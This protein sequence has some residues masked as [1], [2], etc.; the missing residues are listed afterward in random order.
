LR[1]SAVDYQTK[2]DPMSKQKKSSAPTDGGPFKKKWNHHKKLNG[3]KSPIV[4]PAKFQ[5]GKEELGGDYFDCTGYGQS[6]RFMKTVQKVAN[7]IG[8]EYKGCGITQTEV[9][10]QTA[11]IIQVPTRP[12]GVSVMSDNGLTTSIM[13]PDVLDISDYQ[14]ANKI[15]DYQAYNQSENPQKV[16]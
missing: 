5:G 10:T 2:S 12:I 4:R 8:Q 1:A 15:V 3:N 7:H 9:M 11:V 6:D 14:S 13:P 16:F